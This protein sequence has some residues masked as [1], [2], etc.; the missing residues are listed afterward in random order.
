ML[1]CYSKREEE[2]QTK[3]RNRERDNTKHHKRKEE[4]ERHES[5]LEIKD[6]RD[7]QR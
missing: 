4:R 1:S 7:K 6:I 5:S 2:N 3:R